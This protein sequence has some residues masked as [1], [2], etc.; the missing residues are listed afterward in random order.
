MR[1]IFSPQ[2]KAMGVLV[3]SS[4]LSANLNAQ[5]QVDSDILGG[6]SGIHMQMANALSANGLSVAVGASWTSTKAGS[7]RVF[8]LVS[9]TWTLKGSAIIGEA[10]NDESGTSVSLSADGLTVATGA[11][12][13]NGNGASAGHVRVYRWNGSA[14]A[15]LGADIDGI[16]AGDLSGTAIDLAADGNSIVIGA[17][18]NNGSTNTQTDIGTARVFSWNGSAW[19][20]KGASLYGEAIGDFFGYSVSMSATGNRIAVGATSNDVGGPLGNAG[21]V[22]VFDWNAGTT[23]WNQVGADVDGKTAGEESGWSVGLSFTGDTLILGAPK[24]S[25]NSMT[26]AGCARVY[27]YAGSSAWT[28]VS[29][30]INGE[31]AGD[32]S[33]FEVGISY[34][35]RTIVVG[36]PRNNNPSGVDAGHLRIW[37]NLGSGWDQALTSDVDGTAAN[38]QFGRKASISGNG[39]RVAG[40]SREFSSNKGVVRVY[41]TAPN[42]CADGT[43]VW[44]GGGADEQWST[45]RNWV[46]DK[47]PCD[48]ADV[49]FN[50]TNATKDA[51]IRDTVKMASITANTKYRGRIRLEGDTANLT[52][53]TMILQGALFLAEKGK[54]VINVGN[55]EI[56]YNSNVFTGVNGINASG[57]TYIRGGQ[58]NPLAGT[59]LNLNNLWVDA[60]GTINSPTNNG[61]VNLTGYLRRSTG[62]IFRTAGSTW[63]LSG[64]TS[65][66]LSYNSATVSTTS[67]NKL[68]IRNAATFSADNVIVT[69]TLRTIGSSSNVISGLFQAQ[70]RV[71]IGGSNNTMTS[72]TVNA[73]KGDQT[74]STATAGALTGTPIVVSK[75]V[76]G[77]LVLGS[78]VNFGTLTLTKGHIDPNGFKATLTSNS[79]S[80]ANNASYIAGTAYVNKTDGAFSGNKITVPVGRS[81]S[82]KAI[83]IGNSG[84]KND[85]KIEH[86]GS[87]P[88]GLDPDLHS[89]LSSISSTEYWT[90]ER[91]TADTFGTF[92]GLAASGAFDRVAWLDNGS[93]R[94]IGGS[95]SSGIIT[96]TENNLFKNTGTYNLT[97]GVFNIVIPAPISVV[98]DK[99]MVSGTEIALEKNNVNNQVAAANNAS[100]LSVYPNPTRT[101]I[102]V[103]LPA[104]SVMFHVSDMAGRLVGS[105][106]ASVRQLDLSNLKNGMYL[107]TTEVNGT[108]QSIRF[109]KH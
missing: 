81:G 54:G 36:A 44:D 1:N 50:G 74:L 72:L 63:N 4:L 96:S 66:D 13:N 46:G 85:W 3:M 109:V 53:G 98:T 95:T 17:H 99:D 49:V 30:D 42:T 41:T 34:N 7:V 77:N 26:R 28:Q 91:L 61:V 5:S 86:V 38:E 31:A 68:N 89:S 65:H 19:S 35:G 76:S 47:C 21:H 23:S 69:D 6:A 71:I 29:T 39:T 56:T 10:S 92:I 37:K 27:E 104:Q 59:T 43:V 64:N 16:A 57:L 82:L 73:P 25:N 11:P 108:K 55:L 48:G 84:T 33:G 97:Q 79:I 83:V 93:W 24:N 8:E 75:A 88:T 40:G 90:A 62:S 106:P 58:L 107:I 103:V 2:I 87:N 100:N 15:Q 78:D 101:S 102:Q 105:Y 80:G 32:S 60:N 12:N 70:G 22:R 14:W 9:G 67:F 20:Q 94:S 18:S 45:R 52:V 51:I